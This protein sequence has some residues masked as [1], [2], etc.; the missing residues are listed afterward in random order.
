M[1]HETVVMSNAGLQLILVDNRCEEDYTRRR[2]FYSALVIFGPL[3]QARRSV[4]QS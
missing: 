3:V 4:F 1:R 2:R